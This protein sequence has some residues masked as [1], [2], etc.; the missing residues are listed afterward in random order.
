[1][2]KE[3][4]EFPYLTFT[5]LDGSPATTRDL[6]GAS[7]PILFNADCDHCQRES[8]GD[9]GESLNRLKNIPCSL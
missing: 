8:A 2:T 4:N 7:V 1:M 9:T 5:T 3:V 6:P